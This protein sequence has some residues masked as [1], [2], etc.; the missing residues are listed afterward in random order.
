MRFILF[1]I[2][3]YSSSFA[4]DLDKDGFTDSL[5]KVK[6]K[7]LKV[8]L[9][10]GSTKTINTQQRILSFSCKGRNVV[11]NHK[12]GS[13]KHRITGFNRTGGIGAVCRSVRGLNPG[14]VWKSIGSNHFPPGDPRRWSIS[15]IT[16]AGA[17]SPSGNCITVYSSNGKPIA[18][19]GLYRRNEAKYSSR[20]YGAS[21]CGDRKSGASVAA[22]ARKIA[23]TSR[24]Y[25][26]SN[27]RNCAV[28]P[29]PGSCYNSSQC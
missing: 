23:G 11:T 27:G 28:I 8:F 26:T 21:G 9:T 24:V 7:R 25:I 29:N 3:I 16:K 5:V 19:L 17:Q 13:L 12:S 10:T 4:C 22:L 1:C 18:K 6:D 2:L 20:F 15:F 14:E